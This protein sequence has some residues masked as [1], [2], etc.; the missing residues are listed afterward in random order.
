MKRCIKCS[1]DKNEEFFPKLGNICKECKSLYIKEYYKKNKNDI[2]EKEKKRYQDNREYKIEKQ[3]LYDSTRKEEKSLY[4]K[5][6]RKNNKENLQDKRKRYNEINKERIKKTRRNRYKERVETDLNFKL[7]K[8]HRN[9][10]KRILR[11]KKH[12]ST[13]DL[14]GYTS[15]ELRE[16]IESKFKDG[17]SWDNYGEWEIDHIIPVSSFDLEN[18]LPSIVNSLD[19]LQPLWKIENIK[20]SNHV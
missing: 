12:E 8:I 20:K 9:I 18:T 15:I 3:M 17:M 19:N 4:L 2:L 13:S 1:I 11:Y 10:L 5:E 7:S 16:N 14:L 6:Y